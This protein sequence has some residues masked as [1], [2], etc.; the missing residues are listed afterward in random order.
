MS[1]WRLGKWEYPDAEASNAKGVHLKDLSVPEMSS[2]LHCFCQDGCGIPS[3]RP[4]TMSLNL[5]NWLLDHNSLG[6]NRI[7]KVGSIW[8]FPEW[9]IDIGFLCCPGRSQGLVSPMLIPLVWLAD[10]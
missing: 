4:V 7:A 6:W 9:A 8:A 10:Q 2:P 5:L 1:V 3:L